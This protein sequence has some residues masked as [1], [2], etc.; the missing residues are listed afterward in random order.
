MGVAPFDAQPRPAKTDPFGT[1]LRSVVSTLHAEGDPIRLANHQQAGR[2]T[3]S[4]HHGS[5]PPGRRPHR[6]VAHGQSRADSMRKRRPWLS[7]RM[8]AV[9]ADGFLA[10]VPWPA[11]RAPWALR[12]LRRAAAG[13]RIPTMALQAGARGQAPRRWHR[14]AGDPS[15]PPPWA[16]TRQR[17]RQVLGAA[18]GSGC[19]AGDQGRRNRCGTAASKPRRTPGRQLL[20]QGDSAGSG[21]GVREPTRASTGINRAGATAPSLGHGRPCRAGLPWALSAQEKAVGFWGRGVRRRR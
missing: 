2:V 6:C 20:S 4:H 5:R 1:C 15:P 17:R 8:P 10:A 19:L 18:H 14:S 13:P 7:M 16:S 3:Q 9:A 21:S 12:R 11:A